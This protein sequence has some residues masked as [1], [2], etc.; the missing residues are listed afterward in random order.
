MA[1]IFIFFSGDSVFVHSVAATPTVLLAAL[2]K[3][4]KETPLEKVTLSHIHIEEQL[5]YLKPEFDGKY[6]IIV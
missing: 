1:V 4:G 6:L 3:H 2:A 5:D